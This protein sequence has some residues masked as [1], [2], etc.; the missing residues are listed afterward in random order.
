MLIVEF[1]NFGTT[2]NF[3][4]LSLIISGESPCS[5][6]FEKIFETNDYV[7]YYKYYFTLS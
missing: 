7:E 6:S 3:T 4:Y 5:F 2:G 1:T